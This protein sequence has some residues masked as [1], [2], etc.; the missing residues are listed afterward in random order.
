LPLLGLPALLHNDLD[1]WLDPGR[2]QV[3]LQTRTW[4]RGLMRLLCRL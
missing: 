2:R 4:R 1:L 3:T